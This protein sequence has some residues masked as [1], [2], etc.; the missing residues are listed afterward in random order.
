MTIVDMHFKGK[1]ISF[2][3]IPKCSKNFKLVYQALQLRLFNVDFFSDDS[4]NPQSLRPELLKNYIVRCRR[5][6]LLKQQFPKKFKQSSNFKNFR[7]NC[8]KVYKLNIKVGAIIGSGWLVRNAVSQI[9]GSPK[10]FSPN[11]VSPKLC[12]FKIVLVQNSFCK[13]C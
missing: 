7:F 8:K 13:L 10:F 9:S 11:C 3:L 1:I 5:R 4:E 6:K 12:F 2:L